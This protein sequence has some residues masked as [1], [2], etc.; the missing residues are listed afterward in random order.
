MVH[1]RAARRCACAA[2]LAV[3][4]GITAG[5]VRAQD[6]QRR[7]AFNLE[8]Q[9][10]FAEAEVAWSQLANEYPR[11]AEPYAHIGLIKAKEEQYQE[12]ITAYRKAFALDPAMPGLRLNLGLALFKAGDYKSSIEILQPLNKSTPQ[13]APDA[14]RLDILLGMA[15]Y[16]V[17][18]FAA[19]APY[20]KRAS[21]RDAQNLTLLLTLA[22]SCL[23]S[24]QYPCV[25]DTFHRLVALNAE[26]A[27]ADMLVGEALDEMKDP[28]GAVREFRAAIAS[29]PKEPNAHFGL[30]YLLWT[31]GQ[32]PEAAEQFRAEMEN[33]PE[34]HQA[35][36]YLADSYIQMNHSDQARPLLEKLVQ[37]DP[38]SEMT[39]LDLGIV[40]AEAGEQDKALVEFKS[41]IA[42]KPN[43]VK[44]HWRLGRLY[45]AMGKT[46]EANTEFER[47]RALNKAEDERLVKVMSAIPVKSEQGGGT[48]ENK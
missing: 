24:Q 31:K 4:L 1:F 20:L 43:D 15:N 3:F 13:D 44:A 19:A 5:S 32:Y 9:G 29:N 16:G 47:S 28:V 27:E 25:L 2:C 39:H 23:F 11:Q 6:A 38:K 12:A 48:S 37:S 22:H 10:K 30:G 42:A 18:D 17:K 45:R 46:A 21:E 41:A 26:S 34:H 14:Q 35:A 40:Y 8:Q 36:L 7:A 33:N